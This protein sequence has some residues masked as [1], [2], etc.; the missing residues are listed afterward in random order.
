MCKTDNKWHRLQSFFKYQFLCQHQ[1]TLWDEKYKYAPEYL[2]W[3][4]W[5][6]IFSWFVAGWCSLLPPCCYI[7]Y[8]HGQIWSISLFWQDIRLTTLTM[9]IHVLK[10]GW[11]TWS[12]GTILAHMRQWA[13]HFHSTPMWMSI[14]GIKRETQLHLSSHIFQLVFKKPNNRFGVS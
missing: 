9:E 6:Q 13:R 3:E 1:S 7:Q 2:G 14:R 4:H 11:Q 12:G 10:D 8:L 5:H